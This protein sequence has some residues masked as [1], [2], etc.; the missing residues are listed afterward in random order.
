MQLLLNP[1]AIRLPRTAD[2][3]PLVEDLAQVSNVESNFRAST[4]LFPNVAL[5]GVLRPIALGVIAIVLLAA[6]RFLAQGLLHETL[7]ILLFAFCFVLSLT[8]AMR[9]RANL[10]R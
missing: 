1:A 4:R 3:V 9:L 5:A 2:L 8:M 7:L 10:R 6:N